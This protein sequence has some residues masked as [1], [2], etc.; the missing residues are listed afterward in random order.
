MVDLAHSE[1]SLFGVEG[2]T[3]SKLA[4]VG[5]E[6]SAVNWVSKQLLAFVEILDARRRFRQES[7]AP[8]LLS[9]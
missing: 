6:P 1:T 5:N 8:I 3:G 2:S 9:T 4:P 7:W